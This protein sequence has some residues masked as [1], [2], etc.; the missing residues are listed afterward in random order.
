MD[1]LDMHDFALGKI[2][3]AC[4]QAA[5]KQ[6]ETELGTCDVCSKRPGDLVIKGLSVCDECDNEHYGRKVVKFRTRDDRDA[7]EA[8]VRARGEI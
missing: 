3:D 5:K 4:D 8:G 6:A 1:M 2:F 7:Y